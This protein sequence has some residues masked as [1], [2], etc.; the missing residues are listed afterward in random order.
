MFYISYILYILCLYFMLL[1]NISEI[2]FYFLFCL[3]N[4]KY[5]FFIFPFQ[6]A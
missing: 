3:P 4:S 6:K 5:I 1:I 2:F